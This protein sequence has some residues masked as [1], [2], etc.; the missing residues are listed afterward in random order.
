MEKEHMEEKTHKAA[1][2]RVRWTPL[3]IG[4]LVMVIMVF[5]GFFTA[6][7]LQPKS[8]FEIDR[9]ALAGFLPNKTEDEIKAELNRIIDESR[10]N[11]TVNPTPVIENGR[12]NVMVENVPANHYWMQVDVYIQNPEPDQ[13]KETRVYHSGI[14]KQGYYVETGKAENI[15]AP[16]QYNGRAVFTAIKPDT[17]EEIGRVEATMVVFVEK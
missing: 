15:P 13:E 8:Q 17:G 5:T 9:D 16:G 14:I 4:L 7:A 2:K 12:I 1:G 10:F 11:V 3:V 6:R